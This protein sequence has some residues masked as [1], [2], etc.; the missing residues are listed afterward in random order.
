[1]A[2]LPPLVCEGG[3]IVGGFIKKHDMNAFNH[4]NCWISILIYRRDWVYWAAAAV[5]AGWSTLL[6]L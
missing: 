5:K 4:P 3:R 2:A 1:M 6:L